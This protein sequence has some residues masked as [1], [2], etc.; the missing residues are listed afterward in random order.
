MEIIEELKNNPELLQKILVLKKRSEDAVKKR[1][2]Y[3][4][5]PEGRAYFRE[6]AKRY[7]ERHREEILKKQHDYY[8]KKKEKK[9]PV[10]TEKN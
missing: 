2:E 6:K 1:R 3:Q 10:E 4:D 5:T 9:T 8:L 7:Y